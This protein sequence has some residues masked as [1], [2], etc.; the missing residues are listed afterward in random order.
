MTHGKNVLR[1]IKLKNVIQIII[2]YNI[3]GSTMVNMNQPE[4]VGMQV[5]VQVLHTTQCLMVE[6]QIS[7][8][9]QN[10]KHQLLKPLKLGHKLRL[11]LIQLQKKKNHISQKV[12]RNLVLKMKIVLMLLGRRFQIIGV[13]CFCGILLKMVYHGEMVRLATPMMNLHVIRMQA[14]TNLLDLLI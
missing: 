14:R 10:K 7:S 2:A 4:V 6:L 12:I 8:V 5:Y 3:C 11:C 1:K 9:A 13:Y